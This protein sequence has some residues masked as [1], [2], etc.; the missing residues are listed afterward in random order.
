M[1]RFFCTISANHRWR[2]LTGSEERCLA[3]M[4]LNRTIT[5]FLPSPL[6]FGTIRE[7]NPWDGLIP[8][9]FLPD[10]HRLNGKNAHF[11]ALNRF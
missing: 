8:G 11:L 5:V 4:C 10:R 2:R 9:A 3:G 1:G 6:P 7:W